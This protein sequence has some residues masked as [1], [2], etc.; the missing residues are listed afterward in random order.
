MAEIK[1]LFGS[2]HAGQEAVSTVVAELEDLLSRARLG[3]VRCLAI[4]YIDGGEC[5]HSIVRRGD[6]L[7]AQVAGAIAMLGHDHYRIWDSGVE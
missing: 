5:T 7:H 3:E 6:K 4:A 1:A 2:L